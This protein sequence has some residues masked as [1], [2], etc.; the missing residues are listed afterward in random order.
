MELKDVVNTTSAAVLMLNAIYVISAYG[1]IVN[2]KGTVDSFKNVFWIKNLPQWFY[3]LAIFLVIVLLISGPS[4]IIYSVFN[5]KMNK[6]AKYMCYALA[7][8]T[9]LATLLYH[10]PVDSNQKNHLLKNVSIIGGLLL[11]S[12][13][14]K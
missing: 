11:L 4:I 14:Y 13:Q 12:E 9:L 1:K 10:M 6:Y 3:S 2:F 8:F 5:G 7:G